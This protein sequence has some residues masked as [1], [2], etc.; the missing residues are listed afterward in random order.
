MS[1]TFQD[2]VIISGGGPTALALGLA[3]K[4][5]AGESLKVTLCDPVFAGSVKS[6]RA[7][8]LANGPRV[9]LERL[10]IW[11]SI[12][13][14]AQ[15]I[16][17]MVLTDSRTQDVV[18]P[19][20]LDFGQK[21]RGGAGA[22]EDVNNGQPLAHMI[23]NDDL[24][25]ALLAG[26]RGAGVVCIA[27]RCV[28]TEPDPS[29]VLRHVSLAGGG[30]MSASLVVAADG[31]DSL[32]RRK[33]RIGVS[34]HDYHQSAIVFNV[35]HERPHDGRATQHFLPQGPFAILP[36]TGNRSSI[37]WTTH[38][39]EAK[40]LVALPKEEFEEEFSLR[41]GHERGDFTF[42]T[43]PRALALRLQ[44]ARSFIASRFALVGDA[45]HVVH[46]IAGQGLNL[47][48]RDV[49]ALTEAITH[50][51]ALGLD[52]GCDQCLQGYHR[53]RHFETISMISLTTGM[54]ILFSNN[55]PVLRLV[56]DLGLGLV[57]TIPRLKT[58]LVERAS[59]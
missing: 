42:E 3:L 15:P 58:F 46:P 1:A 9:L 47:G 26:C 53:A 33:A 24:F 7:S 34:I 16:T 11:Q 48:L 54:N 6:N 28:D 21:D 57:N 59:S 13:D 8:A 38:T 35:A 29:G 41:F 23:M 4:I 37:V 40:R 55:N 31:V 19:V 39:A 49:E 50:H 44:L 25:E 2:H 12:K 10:G 20:W 32:L 14:N 18:R 45:A 56:R 36:L 51:L 22:L 27:D 17:S 30:T 5:V 52:A 43:K